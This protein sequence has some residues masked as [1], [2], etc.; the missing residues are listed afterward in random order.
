MHCLHRIFGLFLK[1]APFSPER[2]EKELPTAIRLLAQTKPHS[3]F[4]LPVA[5][6]VP[7]LT[8]MEDLLVVQEKLAAF[9][10]SSL[11]VA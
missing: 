2:N 1:A 10:S 4:T 6:P 9:S 7:D 3:V 5:E 8:G 11:R